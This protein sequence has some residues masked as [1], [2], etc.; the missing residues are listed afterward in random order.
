MPR[1]DESDDA[2]WLRE[3]VERIVHEPGVPCT[4]DV[5]E[6]DAELRAVRDGHDLGML[7]GRHG[8]T[9]DS[10]QYLASAIIFRAATTSA[11]LSS[12]MRRDTATGVRQRWTRWPCAWP[13]RRPRPASGSSSSR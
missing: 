1:A 2:A 12:S 7:I 8:Q 13:S 5:V 6:S 11:S 9:I 10:I 3:V 4:V